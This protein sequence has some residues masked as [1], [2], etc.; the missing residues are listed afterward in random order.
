MTTDVRQSLDSLLATLKGE[1][2][3]PGHSLLPMLTMMG[4]FPQYSLSNQLLILAQRPD[5]TRVK[6]YRAWNKAGYQ[7]RKGEKGIAIYAPM[8]VRDDGADADP[9][10]GD[11]PATRLL[12]RVAYVFDVSQVEAVPNFA[13][14]RLDLNAAPA[15]PLRCLE[16]LKAFL[17][18]H[19]L[20]LTYATLDA[21][22]YGWTNGRRITCANNLSP[23][24]EFTTLVH[25]T[26]HALLH[27]PIDGSPRPDLTTRETEAEAVAWLLAE[28]FG[29]P[30]TDASVDYIKAY[31]GTPDTLEA[32]LVR[33]RATAARLAAELDAVSFEAPEIPRT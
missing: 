22:C 17:V 30:G 15:S 10:A 11:S 14:D 9:T 5:A 8:R 33:I 19:N 13:G 6:G 27:F 23:A 3:T 20:E 4:R 16:Q 26:T 2:A 18:G 29:V 21:G 12:Y 25:E 28:Q 7:V 1:L 24:V 31:Q 32:S